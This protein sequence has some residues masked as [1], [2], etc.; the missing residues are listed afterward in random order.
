MSANLKDGRYTILQSLFLTSLVSFS[1]PLLPTRT[2]KS[3][4]EAGVSLEVGID[5]L[6]VAL[7][8]LPDLPY[9][10]PLA[11]FALFSTWCRK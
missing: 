4:I 7:I 6:V 1:T 5:I 10:L 8:F 11:S 3:D 9:N 2:G